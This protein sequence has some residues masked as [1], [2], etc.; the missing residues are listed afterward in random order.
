[1]PERSRGPAVVF[2]GTVGLV[3]AVWAMWFA[4]GLTFADAGDAYLLNNTVM[5]LT[6]TA[7]GALVLTYRPGHRIGRLF[8]AYGLFYAA[9][10]A[11][12][13]VLSGWLNLSPAWEKAVDVFGIMIWAPAPTICLPLILQL[14]P[15]GKPL[16]PRWRWL[17]PATIALGLP[18]VFA[19]VLAPGALANEPIADRSPLLGP[20]ATAFAGVILPFT[21]LAAAAVALTSVV[22]LGLRAW[23]SRDVQRLQLLWLLWAIGVFLVLNVQRVVTTDG[24]IIFVLSLALVPA[25]AT[26]AIVRYGLYDI[27]VIINR[28][29]VYG[30]LTAGVAGAYLGIVAVLGPLADEHGSTGPIIAAGAV[31]LAFAPARHRLQTVV[32]RLMYGER[33][34]PAAAAARVGRRLTGDLDS[35]L[36]AVCE[37]LRLP[38]AAVS[39]DGRLV[40]TY[41]EVPHVR[42]S[43]PLD[44]GRSGG[45]PA[46]L[47]IGLRS[48]ERRLAAADR[49]ALEL[50]AAPIGLAVHAVRLTGELRQSRTR[51]VAAREE[52][53]RRLRRDLHDG[54]GTALT[55]VT[56][57]AD[58]AHNV[59]RVD[60]DR[61]GELL[62]GVRRDITEA[63]ADIRRLVYDLRPPDLDELGLV[64]AL[65]QRAEQT[66]SR[67]VTIT[68][69]VPT[70][71]P[72][73][74]AAVDVA[75]Y[76]IA[77][78][79]VTNTVRHGRATT[80]Q[81]R[82]RIGDHGDAMH[83]GAP[84]A[85]ALH[86]EI[87]D[88]GTHTG[89]P[90]HHGVGL[91]SMHERA[92][93]LGGT[94]TAGPSDTGGRVHAL[95]PLEAP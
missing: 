48:G 45:P 94:F 54:L 93:E 30:V 42:H 47:L 59:L 43:V 51:I 37:S 33:A 21:V 5:T 89:E 2:A 81:I 44:L 29:L 84:R 10:T 8:L 58:A 72:A 49:R 23:R 73:L 39:A 62:L 53:R 24:P 17:V 15:D 40:A 20:D 86:L 87:C 34:D 90:W 83:G 92:A 22:V 3:A 56:L 57:K 88:N 11:A 13:G 75:A 64:A 63:I 6:F 91:R 65:R 27:R 9:S 95:L 18:F 38:Y 67:D 61:A 71:L 26:I 77:T 76:R 7:F 69:D 74:P 31:A 70:E 41:G 66:W 68:L 52:E 46:D 60:L 82:L 28:S 79:A 1:M 19:T 55:A 35:V 78:E 32:D 4:G 80:C 12:L 14:F 16:S 25:A 36:R 85:A 50:L